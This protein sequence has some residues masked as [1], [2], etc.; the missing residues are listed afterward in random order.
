[1]D[2]PLASE[3]LAGEHTTFE[4]GLRK[5]QAPFWFRN[6]AAVV[7]RGL[8]PFLNHGFHVRQS[9]L[10]GGPIGRTTR[11]FRHFGNERLIV[12]TPIDD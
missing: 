12:L 8:D 1:M 6:W 2:A 5:R 10:V 4:G 11:Q 9:F 3:R 7:F